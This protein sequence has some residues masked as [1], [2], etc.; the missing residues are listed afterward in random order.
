M[1]NRINKDLN[2]K[3]SFTITSEDGKRNDSS[4][5]YKINAFKIEEAVTYFMKRK[6]RLF[7]KWDFIHN[8]RSGSDYLG[9]LADKKDGNIFKWKL[10][11]DYKVNSYTSAGLIYSGSSYPDEK[12]EHKLSVEVKAEF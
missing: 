1:R 3:S 7:T 11:L 6:Y 8:L 12:D 10:N 2:L 5:H 4:N 9:F